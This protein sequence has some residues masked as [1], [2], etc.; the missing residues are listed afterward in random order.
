MHV[1]QF[2]VVKG[3]YLEQVAQEC[4]R[5]LVLGLKGNLSAMLYVVQQGRYLLRV[6]A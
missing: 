1:A 3:T 5:K 2:Q 4:V 6:L